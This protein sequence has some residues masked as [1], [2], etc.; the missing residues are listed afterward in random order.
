AL[1]PF[2]PRRPSAEVSLDL[3]ARPQP[4]RPRARGARPA[5]APAVRGADA[6]LRPLRAPVGPLTGLRR[7]DPRKPQLFD[8]RSRTRKDRKAGRVPEARIPASTAA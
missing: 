6:A 2:L 5:G 4:D 8:G 3:P 1:F 7:S